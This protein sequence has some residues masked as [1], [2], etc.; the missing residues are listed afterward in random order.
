MPDDI[1]ESLRISFS[2]PADNI[3]YYGVINLEEPSPGGDGVLQHGVIIHSIHDNGTV[4]FMEF[5]LGSNKT[6]MEEVTIDHDYYLLVI[7]VV[8]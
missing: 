2:N 5:D 1:P 3:T 4:A 7:Y 6:N 8:M